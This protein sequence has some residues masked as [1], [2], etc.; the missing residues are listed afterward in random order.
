MFANGPLPQHTM[1]PPV[2]IDAS[3]ARFVRRAYF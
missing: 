2:S 3:L 1:H